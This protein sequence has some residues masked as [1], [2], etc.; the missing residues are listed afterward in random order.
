MSDTFGEDAFEEL[1]EEEFFEEELE[2]PKACP[3]LFR[4]SWRLY[5]AVRHLNTEMLQK[6]LNPKRVAP[7]SNRVIETSGQIIS[8]LRRR[9]YVRAGCTRYDLSEAAKV[10][11]I[12]A[13]QIRGLPANTRG[14]QPLSRWLRRA[15]KAFPRI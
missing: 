1:M 15:E 8:G 14:L 13:G 9:D 3:T 7:A 12:L 4:D 2:E 5:E 11:D 10:V 6:P